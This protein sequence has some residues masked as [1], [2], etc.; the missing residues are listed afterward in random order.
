MDENA[1]QRLIDYAELDQKIDRLS[2]DHSQLT[3][4]REQ[5]T[6]EK[7]T[8]MN[9]SLIAYHHAHTLRKEVDLLELELL[10]LSQ[11]LAHKKK[12]MDSTGSVK[13]YSALQH[14]VQALDSQQ[15][16]LEESG[17]DLLTRWED[18]QQAYEIIKA[19]EPEKLKQI[20]DQGQ[21]IAKRLQYVEELKN[22]YLNQKN[23]E[24]THVD[25]ELLALYKTM[26]ESAPNP[27]VPLLNGQCSGCFYSVNPRDVSE[28]LKTKLVRCM[29]CYRFLYSHQPV[30]KNDT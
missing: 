2:K 20:E 25:P 24:E 9:Q 23:K 21:E 6:L 30:K 4:K 27:A 28:I 12:L 11:K 5:N 16:L 26:K 10:T 29:N 7:N 3:K 19:E 17:M 8:L 22:A 14:E 1:F 13:E 18:A 15:S